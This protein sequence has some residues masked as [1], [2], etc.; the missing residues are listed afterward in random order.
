MESVSE[1]AGEEEGG[2]IEKPQESPM[3]VCMCARIQMC[4]EL[5]KVCCDLWPNL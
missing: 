5:R 2:V 1:A 3:L 4:I